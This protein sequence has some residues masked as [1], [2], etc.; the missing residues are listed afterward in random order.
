MKHSVFFFAIIWFLATG[1]LAADL[2]TSLVRNWHQWRGPNA[3]GTAPMADP[4]VQWG[5]TENI[6]W[7]VEIPG[8]GSATPIVWND[9]VFVVTA[10]RTDREVEAVEGA[11]TEAGTSPREDG[12]RR[13]FRSSVPRHYYRFTVLCCDR[14]TGKELW[15]R[16]ATEEV[17][18][19]G[20]H[21]TGTFASGS[22][23][24]DGEY[25]YVTFG[26]RGFYCYDMEGVLK[27]KRDLGELRIRNAFGEGSS[28]VLCGEKLIVP[29]DQEDQ[30]S[31]VALDRKT[32]ETLWVVDR[33]EP[34]TWSTPLVV[35]AGGKT[36]VILHGT[37]RVRSYD[38][39]DGRL[40]W[41]CG[42]Q[43][44]NPVACPVACDELV[45]CTTGRQG[46]AISAMPLTAQGDIT[47]T[48][49]VAWHRDDSG[50]YVSSPL[51]YGGLLYHVKGLTSIL[52]CLDAK[53][54]EVVFGPERLPRLREI[55]ASPV[56]AQGRIY[57]TDRGGTT[58][59][60]QHGRELS[61]LATNRLD[62]GVDASFALVDRELF[63]RGSKHLYCI[64]E[65]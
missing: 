7:K 50:A 25:L 22:P 63:I 57:L 12:R 43:A 65:P 27:W 58:L 48:A 23:S 35:H 10:V 5:E 21:S 29:W 9:R 59:V 40:I 44:L 54:G 41:E 49:Q 8:E 14:D 11:A 55:Y 42:G 52:S 26:S 38:P 53:T 46:Y 33:D 51:L 39:E 60:L 30:S 2:E 3:N 20:H 45:Y 13:R 62:D 6:K 47:G 34:T 16:V 28:P 36:Q 4:P 19:E 15:K 37:T 18:H 64:V 56:I 32:G 31:V 17:P 1:V 24:T 61:I